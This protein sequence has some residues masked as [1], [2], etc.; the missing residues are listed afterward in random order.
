MRTGRQR[1]L[2]AYPV[3]ADAAAYPQRAF[4]AAGT[5]NKTAI[6]A[7]LALLSAIYAT[8]TVK[9]PGAGFTLALIA[10]VVVSLVGMYRPR[11]AKVM[12]PAYALLE[13]YVLGVVA[14]SYTGYYG[15]AVPLAV[16][17]T[18]AVFLGTMLAYRTGL[19]RISSRF[20][21][22]TVVATFGLV[23]VLLVSLFLLHGLV[24][25]WGVIIAA[26]AL[27]VGVANLLV[28]FGYIEN[29]QRG[30]LPADAEWHAALMLMVSLVL[31]F[32]SLLRLIGGV[33]GNR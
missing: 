29:L 20:L 14:T 13:G 31:I 21:Q 12:A 2:A 26:F 32:L 19:I 1:L 24:G 23:A 6:L 28:D 27:V 15:G 3:G 8:A 18:A 7:I 33:G 25:P 10:A 9:S 4:S 17:A 16:V 30:G 22:V 11:T 5:F